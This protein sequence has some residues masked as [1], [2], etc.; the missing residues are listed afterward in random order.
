M[1]RQRNLILFF[2]AANN[3]MQQIEKKTHIM[4]NF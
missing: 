1:S 4:Q 3:N 2:K